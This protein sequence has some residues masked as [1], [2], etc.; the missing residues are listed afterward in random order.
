MSA[1]KDRLTV[2]VA[3][4]ACPPGELEG[5]FERH[6]EM[7]G[8]A[9]AAQADI[10]LFPELSL[11]GYQIG[12]R[13]LSVAM[14]RH[15]PRL[16][17]LAEVA[18]DMRV[19][20]GFVEE[21]VAAQFHNTAAV[22]HRGQVAFLH[23]KLNLPTYGQLEEGKHFAAGRYMESFLLEDERWRCGVLVCADT[24]NPALV[25]LAAVQGTTLLLNPVASAVEAV[26]G[27]FSN[28][29][30]WRKNLDFYSLVYGLPILFANH[31]G[32]W[33]GLRFWGGSRIMG[34]EGQVLAEAGEEEALLLAEV[35]YESLRR[36]R[37]LLPTLR[38]SNL[39]LIRRE[40]ARWEEILGVPPESRKV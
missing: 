39:A 20:V 17:K 9:K 24:W 22:L 5:N 29:E 15:D 6:H 12:D 26:G 18:G 4:L 14:D 25:H 11:S 30:G 35:D 27:E 21:G 32:S 1:R 33:Q 28:P 7:I 31:V 36:A 8:R 3:Q 23:R 37:Y 38:D 34:A 40:L 19:T 2:A 10:L 16:L 13:V